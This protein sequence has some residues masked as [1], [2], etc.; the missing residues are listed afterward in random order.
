MIRKLVAL[1]LV[2]LTSCGDDNRVRALI[3]AAGRGDIDRMSVL[4]D[5]GANVNGV[6]LDG[7]T[8]LTQAAHAGQ[9]EAVKLLVARGADI[10]WGT[11]TP[12]HWTAFCGHLNVAKFLVRSGARLNL[13][14]KVKASF[15]DKVRS[16]GQG[17]LWNLVAEVMASERS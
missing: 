12:L 7:W 16:Y 6:A 5:S 3:E 2:S 14:P 1:V 9:L 17:D 8:P 4:I 11:V 10:N 13:D 15:V